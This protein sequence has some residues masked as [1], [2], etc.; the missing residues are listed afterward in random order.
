MAK[1]TEKPLA[2]NMILRRGSDFL[3]H[4]T[5]EEWLADYRADFREA[6]IV[7]LSQHHQFEMRSDHDGVSVEIGAPTAQ[8]LAA[9]FAIFDDAALTARMPEPPAVAPA[10][11]TVFVGHGRSPDWKDFV[12][13]LRDQHGY[14]MRAYELGARAGHTIR[15]ILDELMRES[16]FALLV[17]TGEDETVDGQFHP[18]LNVV[19]EL[20]LFQGRLGFPK[21]IVL[22]EEGTE[23]FSNIHGIQQI[24]YAK[25][26]IRETFGDVLATL[27]REFG[28][29]AKKAGA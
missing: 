1:A 13:H 21:A 5:F 27:R 17:M 11:P 10:P 2:E 12:D 4:D 19:H 24:R 8:A 14:S 28:A 6:N 9:T 7:L 25:G 18:R 20:G 15:D 22:L 3:Q 23:E 29:A 16:A 26:R